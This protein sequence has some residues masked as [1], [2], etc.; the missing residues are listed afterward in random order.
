MQHHY[1]YHPNLILPLQ[2]RTILSSQL[3]TFTPALRRPQTRPQYYP[4]RHRPLWIPSTAHQYPQISSSQEFGKSQL[5][6]L[7]WRRMGIWLCDLLSRYFGRSIVRRVAF[8][9]AS[10]FGPRE[11]L[12][13]RKIDERGEATA[14]ATDIGVEVGNKLISGR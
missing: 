13:R 12:R 5:L 10:L 4:H 7:I 8:R 2:Y 9:K 6:R 3:S 14:T 11:T 1:P